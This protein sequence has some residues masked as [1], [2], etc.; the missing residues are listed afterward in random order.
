MA[1]TAQLEKEVDWISL[2]PTVHAH[3]PEQVASTVEQLSELLSRGSFTRL[4]RSAVLGSG[5]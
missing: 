4:F 1:G 2:T 3:K 5:C